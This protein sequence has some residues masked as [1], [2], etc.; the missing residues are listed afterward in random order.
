ML[1]GYYLANYL[2]DIDSKL[3]NADEVYPTYLSG[4]DQWKKVR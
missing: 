2:E 4:D 3:K 1:K